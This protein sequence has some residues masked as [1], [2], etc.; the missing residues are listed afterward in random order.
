MHSPAT[1][2]TL[3]VAAAGTASAGF[4]GFNYGSTGPNGPKNQADFERDF[5]AAQNLKGTNGIFNSARLYTMVVSF[6]FGFVLGVYRVFG[7]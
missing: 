7:G 1:L 6:F 4:S 5:K 2:L 3:A